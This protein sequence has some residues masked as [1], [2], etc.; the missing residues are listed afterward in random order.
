MIYSGDSYRNGSN[1]DYNLFNHNCVTTTIDGIA[2]PSGTDNALLNGL[3]HEIYPG[4]IQWLLENLGVAEG[5]VY[6][7]YK[8]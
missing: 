1:S 7:V 3:T 5:L 2:G 8:K 6:K 4:R